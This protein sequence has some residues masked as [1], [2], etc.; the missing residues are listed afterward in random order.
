MGPYGHPIQVWETLSSDRGP[1]GKEAVREGD[2][3][4]RVFGREVV[5]AQVS[6]DMGEQNLSIVHRWG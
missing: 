3:N 6:Q 1:G 5:G 2:R 4:G